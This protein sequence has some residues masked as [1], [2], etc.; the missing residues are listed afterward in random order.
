MALRAIPIETILLV[1]S[2]LLLMS[3]LASKVSSRSGVPAL[4]LFLL[5]G[6]LAGSEGPG[7]I[8]F[9]DP[10]LAQFLGSVALAYILFAG[11]MD[12]KLQVVRPVM[13]ESF[14]LS[15]LG[16]ALS[17]L[18]LGLFVH[19]AL[20]FH[21]IEG[22]LLGAIISSTDAAAVFSMLRSKEVRLQQPLEP[23]LELESGSN[24]PMAVFLTISFT[25][26]LANPQSGIYGLLIGFFLQMLIGGGLGYLLG[27]GF[28]ILINRI[29]LQTDGLYSVLSVAAVILIYGATTVFGGNGFL[30]VYLAGLIMGNSSLIHRRSLLRFHDGLAWIMQIVMFLALGLLVFP[31]RLLTIAP[32]GLL[33]ALVLMVAAR[34][35]SVFICLVFSRLSFREK[36]LISWVGLRGAVPIILATFP[37]LAG[38][39]KADFLFNI[40]FFVV[41]T[42]VL[43][44]GTSLTQVAKWLKVTAANFS[45]PV[46][47][48]DYDLVEKYDG[49]VS[50]VEIPPGSS[51]IGKRI[52]EIGIPAGALIILIKRSGEFIVP[53]GGI[54]LAANDRLVIL[55]D[56]EALDETLKIVNSNLKT[57]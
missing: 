21:L 26:L 39:N 12:T 57:R 10:W 17:T 13:R 34:P 20:G 5:L 15:T 6:M 2:I 54:A 4:L 56:Q 45:S 7:G 37:L 19:L 30:A 43:I 31:S 41:L 53:R 16:V 22:L 18:L 40:V 44:Q 47:S 25:N 33:V 46:A 29:N 24:D 51:V 48:L 8:Y 36:V 42:S 50:E 55:S 3:I 32:T 9:D 28:V 27:K 23:L 11:G 49:E 1:A 52:V 35:A 38:L 14:L